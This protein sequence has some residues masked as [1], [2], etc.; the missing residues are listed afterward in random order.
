MLI[1]FS[2]LSSTAQ[3]CCS[4]DDGDGLWY[5]DEYPTET[6]EECLVEMAAR[7]F[8]TRVSIISIIVPQFR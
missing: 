6:W 7:Y 5:T 4:F 1:F 3:W 8:D 2:G